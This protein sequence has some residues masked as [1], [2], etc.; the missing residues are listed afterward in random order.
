M[1]TLNRS[2]LFIVLSGLNLA[3]PAHAQSAASSDQCS[4]YTSTVRG[5]ISGAVPVISPAMLT[6]RDIALPCLVSIIEGLNSSVELPVFK[7]EVRSQFLSA[8]GALRS[9]ISSA[10]AADDLAR[11]RPSQDEPTGS[12]VASNKNLLDFISAFRK[13]HNPKVARV[14]TYAVRSD[15]QAARSNALLIL[16][17]AVDNK[18]VC[19]AIDHLYDDK[20]AQ[21]AFG[22]KGR[23]NLLAIVSVVAPWAYRET[24]ANIETM[25][26]VVAPFIDSSNPALQQT[27]DIVANIRARLARQTKESNQA[28]CLPRDERD[29]YNY[30]PEWGKEQLR[31]PDKENKCVK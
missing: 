8:T 1:M 4:A 12:D 9:M 21:T 19:V 3:E 14:L 20:M 22:I 18:T 17:N 15:D 31:Y 11:K 27:H 7:P 29:C 13:L 5:G 24:Y 28:V 10:I 16:A 2:F 30:P 23:A 25:L 6:N 26:G